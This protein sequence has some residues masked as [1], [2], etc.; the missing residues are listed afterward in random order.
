MSAQEL[1]QRLLDDKVKRSSLK[2]FLQ[3]NKQNYEPSQE[4]I[5]KHISEY[6]ANETRQKFYPD[7]PTPLPSQTQ[8]TF[9]K[10]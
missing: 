8:S 6:V 1:H 5:D 2:S 7:N 10:K 9:Y 4:E 3:G